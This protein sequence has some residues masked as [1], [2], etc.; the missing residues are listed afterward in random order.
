MSY[1]L[2]IYFNFQALIPLQKKFG[3]KTRSTQEMKTNY[4]AHVTQSS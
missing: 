3:A 2:K 4:T 1:K